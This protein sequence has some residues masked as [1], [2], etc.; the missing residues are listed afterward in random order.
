[1]S[2]DALAALQLREEEERQR[3]EGMEELLLEALEVRPCDF[4]LRMGEVS[5]LQKRLACK[6]RCLRGVRWVG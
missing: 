3:R 6:L 2:G 4:M 1:M 5:R